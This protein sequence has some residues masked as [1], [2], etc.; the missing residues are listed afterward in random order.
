MNEE[1]DPL[2]LAQ[3]NLFMGSAYGYA[4]SLKTG[5]KYLKRSAE[6]I[7]RHKLRFVKTSIGKNAEQ[8]SNILSSQEV[9]DEV[10]E[11]AAFLAQTVYV[12]ILAYLMGQ[13]PSTF[14]FNPGHP[15]DSETTVSGC[16]FRLDVAS[17]LGQAFYLEVYLDEENPTEVPLDL[18]SQFRYE[19]PASAWIS[20]LFVSFLIICHVQEAY[21]IL[22]EISPMMLRVRSTVLCKD[23]HN[24]IAWFRQ[25]GRSTWDC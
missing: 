21:P 15:N 2:A 5:K 23:A 18:E 11:R 8:R 9:L 16:S 25:H 1:D 3:A 17:S 14:G 13:T 24:I 19:L 22:F 12:E 6:I 10:Q 4:Q 20:H 7:R